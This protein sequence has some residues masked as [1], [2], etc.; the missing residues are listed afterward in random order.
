MS[1]LFCVPQSS[2]FHIAK[3]NRKTRVVN[4]TPRFFD[5]EFGVWEIYSKR[6]KAS[7][8]PP[9]EMGEAEGKI[10]LCLGFRLLMRPRPLLRLLYLNSQFDSPTPKINIFHNIYQDRVL[11]YIELIEQN[12]EAPKTYL[13]QVM[14]HLKQQYQVTLYLLTIPNQHHHQQKCDSFSLPNSTVLQPQQSLHHQ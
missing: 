9:F 5:G 1:G 13:S 8:L 14:L 6:Q 10:W 4:L 2:A 7:P 11:L 12:R 3:G